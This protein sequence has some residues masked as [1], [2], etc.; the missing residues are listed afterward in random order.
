MHSQNWNDALTLLCMMIMA[1]GKVYQEEVEAFKKAAV[2]L[3]DAVSPEMM[4]TEKMAYDWFVLHK[5][6]ISQ[7]MSS[8]YIVD[9]TREV[10]DRLKSLSNKKELIIALMK[11]A[12]SDGHQH[13]S[14]NQIMLRACEA[15][16]LDPALVA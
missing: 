11:I 10:F 8:V 13:K 6:D 3:K 9:A 4:V 2:Q 16:D 5:D 1:D 14:E 7:K 12:L 15:W